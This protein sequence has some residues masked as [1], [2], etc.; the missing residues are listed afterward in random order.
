MKISVIIPAYN[1]EKRITPTIDSVVEYLDISS[2]KDNYEIIVVLDGSKDKTLEVITKL[3]KKYKQIKIIDNKINQ[4][5]GAVVRQGILESKGEYVLFMDAD[6]STHIDELDKILPVIQKG[7]DIVVGS[8]DVKGSEVEIRQA[9]YKEILGDLGNWWIQILLVGGIQ[10]T[11]CGFKVFSGN[12]A[13]H[14]FAKL[15]MRGWSFDI[16]LLA[17]ARYFGYTIKEMPIIW[18]NDD[19]SHVTLKDYIKVLI[20]TLIIKY[21]LLTGYYK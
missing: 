10:D 5:K 13:R 9:R 19:N 11:Q 8:R 3:S 12:T 21:R 15:S 14:I 18:Y 20:D 1:E 6:N 2:A 16:E 4:G 7:T 17:L